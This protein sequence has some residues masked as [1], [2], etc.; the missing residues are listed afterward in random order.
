MNE[1]IISLSTYSGNSTKR[2]NSA[3][4]GMHLYEQIYSHIKTE[5]VEGRMKTKEK[6]PSTRA[7]SLYL[8]VSRSTVS[9]AYEQLLAEGYIESVPGSGYYVNRLDE[10]YQITEEK[11]ETLV[12]PKVPAK[13][14]EIVF[15]PVGVDLS[16]FPYAVWRRITREVL[17][18]EK[19]LFAG[20]DPQ[21]EWSLRSSIRQYIHAARGVNCT[22]DQIIVGA[23]NE[24]LLM[25]LQKL[26]GTDTVVAFEDP[27]YMKAYRSFTDAGFPVRL[28]SMDRQGMNVAQLEE[29]QARIAYVMPSH[30]YPTGIVMPIGRR[31]EL[32]K[33][34]NKSPDRYVIEDDYDSEFRYKGKPIPSL[35]STDRSDKVIYIG[36]FSK[37]VAPAIRV[38]YMVL[39][40]TLLQRYRE[41]GTYLSATVSRMDQ[42]ILNAFMEGGYFERYLNR[43]RKVY[44]EKH[45]R[46]MMLLAP[47]ENKFTI[48]GEWSGLHLLLT[49]K[50]DIR[51]EQLVKRAADEGVRVYAMSD[52]LVEKTKTYEGG[53]TILL[54]YANLTDKEME[55]GITLLKKAWL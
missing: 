53:A 43:M 17:A 52:N 44:R 24:Y 38:S 47:F 25:L 55:K 40:H 21:G 27:T 9:L 36:T 32:L 5:I 48:K 1:L 14:E 22:E 2:G 16:Q 15:S 8:Q 54:G 18:A 46:L 33:W 13:T 39:P 41:H 23:G 7:L 19:E 35:Q 45:D 37:A 10:L 29:T 26:I 3:E 12:S 4:S 49:A 51:E 28:V 20:G 6:L 50:E 34:A 11:K 42:R 31:L 30:Q